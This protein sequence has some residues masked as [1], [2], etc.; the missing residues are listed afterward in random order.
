[1]GRG[2]EQCLAPKCWDYRCVLSHPASRDLMKMNTNAV[3][4][5]RIRFERFRK[6]SV[7]DLGSIS[8]KRMRATRPLGPQRVTQVF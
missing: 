3:S 2:R 6:S 1:V 5:F 7:L 8:T 4:T